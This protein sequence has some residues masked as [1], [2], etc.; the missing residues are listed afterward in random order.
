MPS[1]GPIVKTR[2]PCCRVREAVDRCVS[3]CSSAGVHRRG[4]VEPIDGARVPDRHQLATSSSRVTT[5]SR[6]GTSPHAEES[7]RRAASA[8]P[9]CPGTGGPRLPSPRELSSADA[10]EHR[11]TGDVYRLIARPDQAVPPGEASTSSVPASVPS[12]TAAPPGC[13]GTTAPSVVTSSRRRRQPA[14]I[15]RSKR[16]LR[17]DR[18]CTAGVRWSPPR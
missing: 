8:C 18:R 17:C 6:A 12:G 7:H 11:P 5:S 10:E 2:R 3:R 1:T 4:A 16:S 9:A 13:V 14:A 15:A